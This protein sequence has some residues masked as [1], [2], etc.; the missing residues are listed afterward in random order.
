M[1]E[2]TC[3]LQMTPV[4]YD[5][6]KGQ[7]VRYVSYCVTFESSYAV[8]SQAG[9]SV[10]IGCITAL[11]DVDPSSV[12]PIESSLGGLDPGLGLPASEPSPSSH[13]YKVLVHPPAG[14]PW[15]TTDAED[16]V[17]DIIRVE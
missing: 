7:D 9:S 14:Q 3:R 15:G 13:S 12:T 8:S 4:L 17:V 10:L 16:V 2:T 6:T 5:P 1:L 11:V